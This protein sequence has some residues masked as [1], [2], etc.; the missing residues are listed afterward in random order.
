M[1][2]LQLQDQPELALTNILRAVQ[3]L[4]ATND[5]P[6]LRL[7]QAL[8]E[9]GRHAEAIPHL[10]SLLALD[11]AHAAARLEL[12]RVKL[13]A[14]DPQSAAGLLAPAL[15]NA[16]TAR[17]AL[18]LLSQVKLR[19]GETDAAAQLVERAA[20]LPRPFDWPD[21]FLREVQSLHTDQQN[22][23]DR[24]NGLIMRGRFVEA[25]KLLE[26]NLAR[27]PE[28]A[29]TLLLF[30]RLRLQQ[31]RCADAAVFFQK[32][33]AVRANSL[34]GCVQ[35][36]L[37]RYCQNDWAAAAAAFESALRL[38]PDFAQAHFNLGLCRSRA[39]QST[40]AIESFRNALRCQP[41]DAQ[42]ARR[43]R[44][45]APAHRKFERSPGRSERSSSD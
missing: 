39:N 3:L 10:E 7:A 42:H 20:R 44:G 36:G 22:L 23:L 14:N 25:E 9:R 1:G 16:Y 33:L 21:P 43:A 35:L 28:S 8:V 18:L 40:A 5:A 27:A 6:R 31:R 2:L 38:K 45:R 37:A 13:A 34:Q 15:T 19:L 29:E 17:P 26:Q 11:P 4:P 41:G 30:G 32:H 24:V 12:A